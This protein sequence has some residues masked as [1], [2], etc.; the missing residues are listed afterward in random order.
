MLTFSQYLSRLDEA[1]TIKR[2]ARRLLPG[3]GKR[4]LARLRHA[5]K[6]AP[7]RR[8][9]AAKLRKW[10]ALKATRKAQP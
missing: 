9:Q 6:W 1:S 4:E 10:E 5:R 2:V 7:V 3:L 8:A